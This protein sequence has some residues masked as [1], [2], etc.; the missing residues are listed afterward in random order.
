MKEAQQV[1]AEKTSS[2]E[3]EAYKTKRLQVMINPAVAK[4][5]FCI[6]NFLCL[7]LIF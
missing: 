7:F 1:V 2:L 4:I 6:L 5:L 3:A